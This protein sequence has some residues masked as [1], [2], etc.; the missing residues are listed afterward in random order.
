MKICRWFFLI[1]G[2][3]VL[4]SPW[5]LGFSSFNTA[6]WSNVIAGVLII[7]CALW[8]LFGSKNKSTIIQ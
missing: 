8:E 6:M 1:L 7:V 5:A 2:L 3:W 4:I